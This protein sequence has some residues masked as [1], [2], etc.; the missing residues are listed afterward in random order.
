[1]DFCEPHQSPSSEIRCGRAVHV[2]LASPVSI[3]QFLRGNEQR[4]TS[5][6]QGCAPQPGGVEAGAGSR[7]RSSCEAMTRA[8]PAEQSHQTIRAATGWG[9]TP[10]PAKVTRCQLGVCG[11]S[12]L[13]VVRAHE[14][15]VRQLVGHLVVER[16]PQIHV[17]AERQDQHP[18]PADVR[19]QR[20]RTFKR[21]LVFAQ[22]FGSGGGGCSSR[23]GT[24]D[25]PPPCRDARHQGTE[26]DVPAQAA[27]GYS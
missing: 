15:A 12:R 18:H 16:S 7:A 6:P 14:S 27:T 11:A 26:E 4:A 24:E 21:G 8:H 5:R 22:A 3:V 9:T 13:C 2:Q 25:L 10:K 1:M 20:I 17:A 19:V 23:L